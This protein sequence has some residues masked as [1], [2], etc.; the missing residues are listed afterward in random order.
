MTWDNKHKL[1]AIEMINHNGSPCLKL[2]VFWQAL[3]SSFNSAQFRSI[4]EIVLNELGSFYSL[5]WPE[6][7]EEEFTQAII[8]C[9]DSS[10]PKPNKLL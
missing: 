10:S 4:D 8:N 1:P 3:H 9:C 2:N 6:F 7:S 5:S